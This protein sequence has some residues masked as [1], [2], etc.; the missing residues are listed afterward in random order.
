[1][2][3]SP[4]R[5]TLD[6]SVVLNAFN[7]AEA[8]HA[9]SFQLQT[10]LQAQAIPVVVPTLLLAEIV[11]MISRVLNDTPRAQAFARRLSRPPYLEWVPLTHAFGLAAA[12][13]AA[14]HRLRG[15]DAVYAAVALR[16]GTTLI[17]LDHEHLTRLTGIVSTRTPAEVLLDLLPSSAA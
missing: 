15:A 12:D 1:M 7:S 3:I 14:Q 9:I 17:T 5:Y 4:P 10:L 8:G 11:A 16:S 13:L 6:A 2:T